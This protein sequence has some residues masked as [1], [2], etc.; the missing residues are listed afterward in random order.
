MPG[1]HFKFDGSGVLLRVSGSA[2]AVGFRADKDSLGQRIFVDF[3][4]LHDHEKIF[5]GFFDQPN[6]FQGI[7]INQ[8]QVCQRTI[9][10][11][12]ELARKD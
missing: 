8:Q 12:T 10:H 6:T 9:F 4:V 3:A 1:Q 2:C 5:V 7:A 11:Y